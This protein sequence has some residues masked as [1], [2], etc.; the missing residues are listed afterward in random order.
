LSAP[1]PS[2]P[3]LKQPP[4]RPEVQRHV[5]SGLPPFATFG[6]HL[7][8]GPLCNERKAQS[9]S[10]RDAVRFRSRHVRLE[11]LRERQRITVFDTTGAEDTLQRTVLNHCNRQ[12]PQTRST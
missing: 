11:E 6:H 8:K 5:T 2:A 12:R 7:T 1:V 10:P 4:R 3:S 9:A